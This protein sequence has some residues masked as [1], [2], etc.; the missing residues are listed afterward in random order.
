MLNAISSLYISLNALQCF[1]QGD[2]ILLLNCMKI[3][4]KRLF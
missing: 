2:F 4:E 3:L 1:I